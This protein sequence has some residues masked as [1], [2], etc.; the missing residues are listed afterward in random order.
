MIEKLVTSIIKM[1][2]RIGTIQKDDM[3]IYQYG[4]TLLI[5]VLING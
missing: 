2:L 1:Q 5:E 3:K 4:Y